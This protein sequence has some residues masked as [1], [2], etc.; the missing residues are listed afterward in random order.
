MGGHTIPNVNVKVIVI[1]TVKGNSVHCGSYTGHGQ[2]A[3]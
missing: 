2:L 1:Q 3:E